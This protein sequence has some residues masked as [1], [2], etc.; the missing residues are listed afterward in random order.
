[1]VSPGPLH[2][3]MNAAAGGGGD[4]KKLA[5]QLEAAGLSAVVE[6]VDADNLRRRIRELGPIP[7]LG[8]AGGDGSQ[9]TAAELLRGTA[10]VL[11]PFPTGTLNHFARRMG[12][13]DTA[14]AIAAAAGGGSQQTSVGVLN[15]EREYTFLNTAV[16]GAYPD[17]IRLRER[18]RPVMGKWPAAFVAGTI[19]W[20]RWPCFDLIIRTEERE[21][22]RHTPMIWIGTGPG[23]FPAPHEAP[24]AERGDGL[25][26]VLL[27]PGGRRH[28]VRLFRSLWA[29]RR[30]RGPETVGLEVVRATEV[31]I[32]S[33][34]HHLHLTLDA[35]PT[36]V[37]PPVRITLEA[38]SLRAATGP[39]VLDG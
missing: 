31:E 17:V 28:G 13:A 10:T 6:P 25:E 11:I 2:V 18:M 14:Q 35:E 21:L 38:G 24:V 34:H 20:A 29:R 15:G 19:M 33:R 36:V 37:R 3:L 27:P 8:I 9:R 1:M 4:A 39:P 30:G 32:D 5:E 12:I 23:T 16:V 7:R 26:L 22:R